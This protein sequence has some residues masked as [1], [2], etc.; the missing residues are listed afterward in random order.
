MF[1]EVVRVDDFG[2]AAKSSPVMTSNLSG[3]PTKRLS[4]SPSKGKKGGR[5]SNPWSDSEEEED[6]DLQLSDLSDDMGSDTAAAIAAAARDRGPRRAAGN[7]GSHLF[8][9]LKSPSLP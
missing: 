3:S 8:H 6:E 9:K 7:C 2:C 5:K 1:S 4:G